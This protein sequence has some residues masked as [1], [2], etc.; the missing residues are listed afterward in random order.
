MGPATPGAAPSPAAAPRASLGD[1]V[2]RAIEDRADVEHAIERAEAQPTPRRSLVR[3]AV[4]LGITA[5]SLYLVFPSVL[6]VLS[7]WRNVSKLNWAWLAVMA[8]LQ[9]ATLACLW[10]LQR[11]A[12]RAQGWY[13]VVTSQ[14]AGNAL[15]KVA[16]G[17]GAVGAA[18]Q[19]RMLVQAGLRQAT[20]VAG[21]TAVSLLTFAAVLALPVFVVRHAHRHHA[22]HAHRFVRRLADRGHSE[23]A[24]A[25]SGLRR[26]V[27]RAQ[28]KLYVKPTP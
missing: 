13:A 18:L 28:R 9:V 21:L 2:E 8:G 11:L 19:Y 24:A 20:V 23:Q 12:L 26:V 10:A 14:L 3:R 17:G 1:R 27:A 22:A 7:S 25:R 5:V 6:D 16:P 15:S 4:W